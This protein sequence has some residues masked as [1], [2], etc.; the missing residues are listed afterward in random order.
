[1]QDQA[2][3]A[4]PDGQY[5]NS[6]INMWGPWGDSWSGLCAYRDSCFSCSGDQL[7]DIESMSWVTE[8][9]VDYFETN[10]TF[11]SDSS[12]ITMCRPLTYY[13]NPDSERMMELGTI[14]YPFKDINLVF[15]DIFNV[16]QH[17]DRVINIFIM[18]ATDSYFTFDFI[19][20]VNT[21]Q[22]SIDSY[23]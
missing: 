10:Y 16:H 11:E 21:T 23:T 7:F 4:C 17:T 5:Y 3:E 22:V 1:M 6:N 9:S 13:V 8:C 2:W 15:L 20:I 18:E 19:K 14:E 12:T